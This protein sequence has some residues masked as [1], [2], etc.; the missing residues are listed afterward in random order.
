MIKVTDLQPASLDSNPAGTHYES[1]VV[2][3]RASG[4]NC[5]RKGTKA[6]ALVP[7]YLGRHV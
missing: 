2:A 3:G 4:Q 5:S 1:L 6:G 7:W